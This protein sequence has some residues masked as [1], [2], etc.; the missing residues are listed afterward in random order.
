[1]ELFTTF[2]SIYVYIYYIHPELILGITVSVR[3]REQGRFS[4]EG[5]RGSKGEH[6]GSTMR[7]CRGAAGMISS[8]SA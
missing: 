2:E 3:E 1:M 6:R 5:A 4:R 7:Q 8:V